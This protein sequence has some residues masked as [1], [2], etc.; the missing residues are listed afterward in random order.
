VEWQPGER[1]DARGTPW[2]TVSTSYLVKPMW[3][4]LLNGKDLAYI[5]EGLATP[6]HAGDEVH[7]FPP[8]R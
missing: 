5:T 7:L 8:G 6:L 2:F 1:D 4:V 3:R